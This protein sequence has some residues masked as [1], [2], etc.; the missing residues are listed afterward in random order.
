VKYNQLFL[1]KKNIFPNYQHHPCFSIKQFLYKKEEAYTLTPIGRAEIDSVA[2]SAG[3]FI[4]PHTG[5]I[6][7]HGLVD[8]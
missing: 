4:P 5:W 1:L 7:G 3:F 6:P 2:S 8:I